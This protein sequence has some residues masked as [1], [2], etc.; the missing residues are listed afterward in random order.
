MLYIVT[1]YIAGGQLSDY[2]GQIHP[3][4]DEL[5]RLPAP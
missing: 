4:A 3:G 5:E 2:I 1:A